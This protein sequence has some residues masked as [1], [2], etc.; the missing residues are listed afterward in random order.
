MTATPVGGETREALPWVVVSGAILVSAALVTCGAGLAE[1]AQPTHAVVWGSV[2][3]GIYAVGLLCLMVAGREGSLGLG[4]WKLGP[5]MLF[6]CGLT[7][8][9]ATL[10]WSGPQ[11]STATQIAVASVLHALWLVAV[12]ATCLTLG[13]FV[14]L[15]Q[16]VRRFAAKGLSALGRYRT[17][18]VRSQFTPW[19][20]Y[21]VGLVARLLSTATT[22]RFGY[23]GD[24][25]SAVNAASSYGQFLSGL[26]LLAP[27]GVAA[28]ALQVCR[29]RLPG[30]RVTLAVLFVAELAFGAAAGGKESFVIAVLAVIIPISA[31]RHRLPKAAIVGS[32]LIFLV[33]VIPFNQAYRSA[34]RDGSTTLTPAQAVA[35]APGIFQQTIAVRSLITVVP[36]SLSYLML[37]IREID[38]PA[39]IMQRTP[40]QVGYLSPVQ[41]IEA[42]VA[43]MVPRAIWPSKPI[44]ATGYQ[45]SQ[46]YF[47]MPSTV[48]TS[49]AVTPVGDLYRHGGWIPVIVGMFLL[50]CSVRLL[51]DVL[52]VRSNPM[53]FS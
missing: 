25:S 48:Y 52:D 5:W 8:G 28:A 39:I 19:A 15:G 6:W 18:T 43:D 45:F 27:L 22:G 32:V 3:L 40:G 51:D 23:V 26:S 37:R 41:L 12:G 47:E 31:A 35:E 50:G 44:L 46:Q 29:E 9:F 36:N 38:S 20:L 2:A 42:P 14:G 16:G 24:V 30:A 4:R 34:A 53:L 11:V 33:V 17:G 49:S 10:T 7:S 1:A 13:Y 21:G